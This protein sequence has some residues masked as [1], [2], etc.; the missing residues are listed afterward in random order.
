M[1]LAMDVDDLLQKADASGPSTVF[2]VLAAAVVG[3]CALLVHGF[4]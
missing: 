2:L 1:R 3:L 4:S